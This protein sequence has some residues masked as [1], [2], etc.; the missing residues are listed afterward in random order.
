MQHGFIIRNVTDLRAGPQFRSER[1]SQLLY[2]EPV[3]ISTERN[4]YCH[5]RQI[6]GYRGWVDQRTL[7]K[8]SRNIWREYSPKINCQV[9]AVAA[10]VHSLE[11]GLSHPPFFFYGTRVQMVDIIG[12]HALIKTAADTLLRLRLN[13]IAPLKSAESE[14]SAAINISMRRNDFWASPIYGAAS[15]PLVL[16]ARD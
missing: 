11:K 9:T 4:G 12:R 15:P 13:Q 10:S 5:V 8:V 16:I 7:L 3:T 14:S 1:K 2:H 6:D